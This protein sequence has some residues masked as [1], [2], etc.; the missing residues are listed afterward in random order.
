MSLFT[1]FNKCRKCKN[2]KNKHNDSGI[3]TWYT[4]QYFIWIL[5]DIILGTILVLTWIDKVYLTPVE[6]V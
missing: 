1:N 5:L 2:I 3:P 4:K 6:V